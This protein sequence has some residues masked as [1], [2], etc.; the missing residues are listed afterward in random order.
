[1][2]ARATVSIVLCSCAVAAAAEPSGTEDV[3]H[4]HL[5]GLQAYDAGRL[6]VAAA[7]FEAAYRLDPRPAILWNLGQTYRLLFLLHQRPA[8]LR[9]SVESYR[10]YVLESPRGENRAEAERLLA[11]LAPLLLR[12]APEPQSAP[13]PASP[14]KTELMIV[15]EAEHASVFLDDKPA[16]PAPLL[17]EVTPGEHHARV[18]AP[19]YF[20]AEL[21]LTAVAGRLVTAEARLNERP[22]IVEVRGP[23]AA[24]LFVDQRAL[25]VLPH[26]PLELPA[27]QHVVGLYAR[28]AD[29]WLTPLELTRGANLQLSGVLKP[30]RQRRAA[31]W[32][33]LTAALSAALPIAFGA[34]WIEADLSA[35]QLDAQRAKGQLPDE[36]ART[37]QS[38]I[39]RSKEFRVATAVSIGLTGS[40]ALI[41]GALYYFDSP[42]PAENGAP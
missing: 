4:L 3:R 17:G 30:S 16:A 2:I 19:G 33:A 42:R 7:S 39:D 28:G 29:P 26:A 8:D 25:G 11:E 22:A 31:G 23:R 18:E 35:R 5:A 37:L 40:L 1:M 24:R 12:M 34:T 13:P 41:V 32:L 36:Q 38:D 6:D 27:G 9:S 15:A 20:A 10:R 14:A 21:R